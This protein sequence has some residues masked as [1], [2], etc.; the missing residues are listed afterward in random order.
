MPILRQDRMTSDERLVALLN[1]KPVDR[2]P[3]YPLAVGFSVVN[4]G[5]T[6][7]DAYGDSTGKK[8]ADATRWMNEQYGFNQLPLLGTN[9]V[10]EFGGELTLPT[11]EYSQS[12]AI[13]RHGVN[14][15]KE[16]WDLKSPPDVRTSGFLLSRAMAISKL[17]AERGAP[18]IHIAMQGPWDIACNIC[19]IERLCKWA[20]R[21]KETAHHLL[22]LATDFNLQ[23]I[24][25][26]AETFGAERLF[27]LSAH[28]HTA[29]QIIG[30][31]IFE[32][33][34][35]P[36]IK[37]EH[38]KMMGMG[39]KN[40]LT[41]VCGYHAM[42]YPMWA[43]IPMGNPG[44]ISVAHDMHEDWPSPLESV[45]KLFPDDIIMGN[46]EPAVFQV[47]TP[48]Q[49]YELARKC[50]EIGKKHEAGFVLGP[51][52]ELPP[53]AS[54]YNVWQMTKAVSDHGWYE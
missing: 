2:V 41:H 20:M 8:S 31:K 10:V 30:P 17:E 26:W 23:I 42:N 33:F 22:R 45:G 32:E 28:P 11:G 1:R 15:S 7:F 29:A 49:V 27:P 24:N 4:A 51:G 35:F 14:T 3:I 21:E 5:F 16:A 9:G 52:C 19:G 34:C 25:W 12:S 47:G 6:I 53:K 46:I 18:Y 43:Q 13:A 54:P 36:Y 50:I 38:E 39:I 37:E 48:G 40:I 44:I